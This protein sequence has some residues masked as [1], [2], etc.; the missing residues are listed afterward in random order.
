MESLYNKAYSR[1][2]KLKNRGFD[3]EGKIFQRSMSPLLFAD[4]T[5]KGILDQYEKL[6][7]FMVEKVKYIKVFYNYTVSKNYKKLN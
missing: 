6:V 1:L 3:Y 7:F 5:R 4:P 2:D